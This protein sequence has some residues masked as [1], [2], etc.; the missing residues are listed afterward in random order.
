MD[1]RAKLA[2]G[3]TGYVLVLAASC[4]QASVVFKYV[5]G[6]LERSPML[7]REVAEVTAEEIRLTQPAL[8]PGAV[9]T[10]AISHRCFSS[11]A[12]LTCSYTFSRTIR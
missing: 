7:R 5:V 11:S 4:A 3:E 2:A 1:H 12:S 6:F 8:S 10:L 9:A